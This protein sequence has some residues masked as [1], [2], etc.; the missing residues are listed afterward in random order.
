MEDTAYQTQETQIVAGD[1][2]IL[3]TDGLTEAMNAEQALF[4]QQRI[5]ETVRGNGASP[6]HLLDSL[7]QA[8]AKF[9]D[10]AEQSDDLTMLAILYRGA[11]A[12]QTGK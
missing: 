1:M 10:G 6:K 4:G 2:V 9:V 3:Y 11:A 5:V 8:V 12:S 7:S